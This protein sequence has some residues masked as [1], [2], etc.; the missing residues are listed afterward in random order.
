MQRLEGRLCPFLLVSL[1]LIKPNCPPPPL[2]T[3]AVLWHRR[4]IDPGSQLGSGQLTASWQQWNLHKAGQ[5]A[6][7]PVCIADSK[8]KLSKNFLWCYWQVE[9]VD[10]SISL[11]WKMVHGP[12]LLWNTQKCIPLSKRVISHDLTPTGQFETE[13][14]IMNNLVLQSHKSRDGIK[15]LRMLCAMWTYSTLCLWTVNWHPVNKKITSPKPTF[16]H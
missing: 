13:Y 15:S 10:A 16:H 2:L 5:L 3:P 7:G 14:F 11:I 12:S 9:K 4:S 1:F 6:N 8:H